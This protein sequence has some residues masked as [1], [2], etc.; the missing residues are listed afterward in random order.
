[1]TLVLA[2][3]AAGLIAGVVAGLAGVRRRSAPPPGR[4]WGAVAWTA[5]AVSGLLLLLA[6]V[7]GPLRWTSVAAR[8]PEGPGGRQPLAGPVDEGEVLREEVTREEAGGGPPPPAVTLSDVRPAGRITGPNAVNGTADRWNVHATDLG[9]FLEYRGELR[10][11][12]GD[13]FGPGGLGGRD[14][15]SNVMGVVEDGGRGRMRFS[16]M[17]SDRPGHARELLSSR[18]IDGLEKTVI[19]TFGIAVGDRLYL[20]YMSV[21][22]WQ[23]PGRWLVNH[24]GLAY[25]DDG[26]RTWTKHPDAKW[27]GDGNFA[28]VAFVRHQGFIYL[29]GIP[30]GRFGP[31][32]LARVRPERILNPASYRYWDGR[33]WQP[34]SAAAAPVVPAPVGELSVAWSPDHQRWIMLYLDEPRKGIVVRTAERLTGPWSAPELVVSAVDFPSLYAPFIVPGSLTEGRVAFT[35]SRYGPYNIYLLRARVVPREEVSR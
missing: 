33:T 7:L 12:F 21:R 1:M 34:D 27:P 31:A 25:S 28:Q 9:H 18:K 13:T 23:G 19:P 15:R 29:F 20:H 11:T 6:A 8:E 24:A 2:L 3:A 26:G 16:A 22:T 10:L 35:M 5:G 17:V 32:A 14:W 4:P 30:A